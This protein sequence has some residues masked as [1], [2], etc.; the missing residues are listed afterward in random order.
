MQTLKRCGRA[1]VNTKIK[2][3]M[4]WP[5]CW[6]TLIVFLP[7]SNFRIKKVCCMCL[8]TTKQSLRWLSREGIPQWDMFP[9]PT[10]LLLFGYSIELILA[11]SYRK[12]TCRHSNQRKFYTWRMESFVVLVQNQPFQFRSLF[13]SNG[14]KTTT[15]FR[16]RTSHCKITT[17]DEPY[18]KG[19]HRTYHP[20]LQEAWVRE[21]MEIKIPGVLMLRKRK[22]WWRP[23]VGSDRKTA[24]DYYHEQFIERFF[25]IKLLK[26]GWFLKSGNGLILRCANDRCAPLSRHR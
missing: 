22:D 15:K 18:C 16:R 8:R 19:C 17:N 4:E 1:V 5:T 26:V 23:V 20:R 12:P 11:Q 2:V 9:G 13:W 7:A 3:V 21:V 6:I 24:S 10:E 14:Q 25:L